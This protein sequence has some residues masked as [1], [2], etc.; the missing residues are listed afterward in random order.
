MNIQQ[1]EALK[2]QIIERRNYL[3]ALDVPLR[4]SKAQLYGGMQNRISRKIDRNFKNKVGKQKVAMNKNIVTV[5]SY[6]ND[7]TT[8]NNTPITQ[9]NPLAISTSALTAPVA[10]SIILPPMPK[11]I[12]VARN[13]V[14]VY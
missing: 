11:R 4:Y 12:G 14:R 1:A 6:I 2:L 7:L 5:D 3:R 8:Y 9:D 10:P 13:T